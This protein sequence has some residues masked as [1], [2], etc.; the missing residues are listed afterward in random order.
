M[1]VNVRQRICVD[2]LIDFEAENSP[3]EISELPNLVKNYDKTK[4]WEVDRQECDTTWTDLIIDKVELNEDT[5]FYDELVRIECV[6]KLS[7]EEIW[8][9][10]CK[11]LAE[12]VAKNVITEDELG[13]VQLQIQNSL[14]K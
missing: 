8:N 2:M 6:D 13:I 7:N 12:C 5:Q 1:K 3:L 14:A 9:L 11:Q 10:I 4:F